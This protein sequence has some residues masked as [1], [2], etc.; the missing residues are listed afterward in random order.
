MKHERRNRVDIKRISAGKRLSSAIVYGPLI[1]LSGQT[2][3]PA[4]GDDIRAQTRSVLDKIDNLL[5]QAGTDKTRLLNATIW[6][7]DMGDFNAMNDVWETWLTEGV[8]PARATVNAKLARPDC[9]VEIQ[10]VAAPLT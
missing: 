6:L 5:G 8:V 10:V 7:A 1:W 4:V 2:P 3:D 9:K